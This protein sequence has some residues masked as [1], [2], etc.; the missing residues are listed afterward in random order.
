MNVFLAHPKIFIMVLGGRILQGALIR[1]KR[2]AGRSGKASEPR[3][4]GPFP[5]SVSVVHL[6]EPV[7][8]LAPPLCLRDT[9][10][11]LESFRQLQLFS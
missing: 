6:R 1:E 11:P 5:V 4:R 9:H 7:T 8:A 3:A 10:A 2:S